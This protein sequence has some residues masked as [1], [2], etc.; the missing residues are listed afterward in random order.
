MKRIE[1]ILTVE[2]YEIYKRHVD[3]GNDFDF[4]SEEFGEAPYFLQM[5]WAQ[6]E[7]KLRRAFRET[8]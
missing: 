1:D 3:D 5:R 4:L 6:I 2:E 8:T 7:D